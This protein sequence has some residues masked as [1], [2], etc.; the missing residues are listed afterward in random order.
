VKNLLFSAVDGDDQAQRRRPA[1][2]RDGRGR[3]DCVI[4][5]TGLP[6]VWAIAGAA[7]L[8]DFST[9]FEY[10]PGPIARFEQVLEKTVRRLLES[11]AESAGTH[12]DWTPEAKTG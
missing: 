8:N 2:N 5:I 12:S 11:T 1:E 3:A 6:S 9:W 10:K 4:M 7:S